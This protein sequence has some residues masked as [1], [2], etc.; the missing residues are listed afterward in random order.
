VEKKELINIVM[1]SLREVN[2][3]FDDPDPEFER[4]TVDT[5]IFGERGLLD[6][7]GLVTLISIIESRISEEFNKEIVIVTEKAMSR[8]FSPFR[9]IQ[10]LAEFIEK[11]LKE[12]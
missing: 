1:E 6:S 4:L 2:S 8:K 7:L 3:T 9:S 11:L 5:K 10:S 12:G